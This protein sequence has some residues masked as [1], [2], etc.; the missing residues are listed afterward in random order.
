MLTKDFW[1]EQFIQNLRNNHVVAWGDSDAFYRNPKYCHV[2]DKLW[3]GKTYSKLKTW[4][5][6]K[7]MPDQFPVYVKPRHNFYGLSKD[8]YVAD[9]LEEIEDIDKMIAQEMAIGTHYSTDYVINR[10]SI[11]DS[12]TFIGH[13]NF[14]NDFILWESHP[15]PDQIRQTIRKILPFYTGICNVESIDGKIIEMHLRGSLQFYDICGGLLEQMPEFMLNG[16]YKK[17]GFEKTYSKV[18]RTRHDGYVTAKKLPEKPSMV[19]SLQLCTTK[20]EKLSVDDPGSYRRR[21]AVIN[22]TD[23]KAIENYATMLRGNIFV[24]D[25]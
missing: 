16:K 4:D 19:R 25:F 10:G 6:E 18:L 8:S 2:Y 11:V 17:T 23:L 1:E 7:E 24:G 15:F 20:G 3:L 21:F 13:K 14:Y 5:L 12:W 9:S 22:G